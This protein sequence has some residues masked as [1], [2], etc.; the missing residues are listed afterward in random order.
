MATPKKQLIL[1]AFA[2]QAPGHLNPGLFKYPGDQ[3]SQYKNIQ[4]WIK[5]AQKLEKAKFHAIFFAVG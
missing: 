1:N 2:M 5:L 3:G 4:T